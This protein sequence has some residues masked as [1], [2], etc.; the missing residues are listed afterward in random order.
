MQPYKEMLKNLAF[1]NI[2]KDEFTIFE[3]KPPSSFKSFALD[4]NVIK[5]NPFSD[6]FFHINKGNLKIVYIRRNNLLYSI[7]ATEIQYQILEALIE[8]VSKVF[9]EIY[10]ID[11]IL[12]YENFDSNIFNSFKSEIDNIINTFDQLKLINKVNVECKICNKILPVYVKKSF[13]E[14]AE[15][16]PVPLVYQHKGHAILIFIDVNYSVRG[17]E[18]VN[19]TG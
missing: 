1:I 6:I 8:H 2:S 14:N 18:L 3:W 5:Q 19:M 11:I 4:V 17:I 7:G 13:I 16:H 15:S 10:D 9:H 12:S